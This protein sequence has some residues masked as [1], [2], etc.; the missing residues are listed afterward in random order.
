MKLELER[1]LKNESGTKLPGGTLDEIF[2]N[3]MNQIRGV[4]EENID[5]LVGILG[6]IRENGD[7]ELNKREFSFLKK[8][9]EKAK[10]QEIPPLLV[11]YNVDEVFSEVEN[12]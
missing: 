5:Q 7:I 1:P 3:I 4:Q 9:W 10:E 2:C 6:E 11:I 12:G 8:M